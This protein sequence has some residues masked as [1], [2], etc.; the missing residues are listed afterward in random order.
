[1]KRNPACFVLGFY[2]EAA[3]AEDSYREIQGTGV[4]RACL[5]KPDGSILGAGSGCKQFADLRLE[6]ES[7]LAVE[8]AADSVEAVAGRLRQQ[9]GPAVFILRELAPVASPPTVIR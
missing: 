7:L 3:M 5:L 8:T 9:G 6:A 1:M 2:T 4:G